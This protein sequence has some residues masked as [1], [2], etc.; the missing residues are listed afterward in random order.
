M[1]IYRVERL[2]R[3]DVK[4]WDAD[5]E[6]IAAM[7]DETPQALYVRIK[8]ETGDYIA[9]IRALRD[10]YGLGLDEAK[11]I[12]LIADGVAS[13]LDQHRTHLLPALLETVDES[14]RETPTD[15]DPG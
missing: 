2:E 14:G 12:G 6:G 10:R 4:Q 11:E 13:S 3:L 7:Q 9:A 5:R 8:T 1:R 15:L